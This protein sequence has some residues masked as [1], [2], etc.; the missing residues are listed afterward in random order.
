[1]SVRSWL[2]AG[3]VVVLTSIPAFAQA[4][5]GEAIYQRRCAACHERPADGRT[6][7]RDALQSMPS[8]RIMR[9]LDFGAMMTIAYQLNRAEREAVAGFLGKP[10]GEPA[11]RAEAFCRD[12]T[13]SID[14]ST[15][16]IWNG[17]SPQPTNSRFAPAAL[18]KL[19]A[20]QVARLKLK[21]AFGFEGDISAF[22]QPTVIGNQAFIG[23]AGGVVHAL[24]ADTGCLQ[25]TFQAAGSIRSAIVAAPVDGRQVLLFGDL[26]GWFYALDAA[27]G[28]EIW[29]K[30]PEE[31]E[32]VRLSAP[33][34]VVDGV[35]YVGASSWEESRA[36]NPE[37]PCCT[38]RGSVTA[39]RVR[40]GSVVWKTY[41]IDRASARTGKT[42]SG[43]E[44][45]GP[46]GVGIWSSPT[47][48][49]KRRRLY[50]TTGNNYSS[51]VTSTS[52]SVVALDLDS[53]RMIWSKQLHADD[54]YN[55]ACSTEP[56]GPTCPEGSGPDYDFGSPAILVSTTGG[57]DLLL[58][59]QKSG[60]VWA[61]DPE[62]NGEIMWET[63]VAQGGI[64]GG[65]Q[66]GMA[67]DGEQVY[68]ATSD[69]VVIRTPTA[70]QLDP[71]RGGGLTAL[72][73]A[74][75]SRAWHAPAPP[76]GARPNCSPAQLAAVTA[77]PGVVFSGSQD[78]HLRAYSTRDGALVWDFDT[79]QDYKTVNGVKGSGG[80]IDGPGPVIVNGMVFVNSGY[81]RFGGAPGNVLLAFGTD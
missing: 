43:V 74:D 34:V 29:R 11:P 37:Y 44:T 7:S 77:I 52:D 70:R 17:W 47:L 66:W 12:R 14:T 33:P 6:P 55:S 80:A 76:C 21:W 42:A 9:T 16:P 62:K 57:R 25:W 26:T 54:V 73:I 72:K 41:T 53:G 46:S 38:F 15:T 75:G 71:Q 22:S 5:S 56:K 63:R 61:I 4:P 68:A 30:R 64:N 1:M 31:H 59:G 36:L 39:L 8:T 48:D 65:V 69:V 51:P 58:A 78:G 20:D 35:A 45:W 19:T 32:A 49:V 3:L 13:V 79:V 67:A 50:V 23:S 27:T 81:M 10:G 28:K 24:R 40:D 2:R 60:I 18:A